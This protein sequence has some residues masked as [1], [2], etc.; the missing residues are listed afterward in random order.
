MKFLCR[1]GM[2]G[3]MFLAL[4]VAAQ[5]DG[6]AF[7]GQWRQLTST[8]GDCGKC[9]IGFV[10]HGDLL[11][12]TSNTGW[13][14]VVKIEGFADVELAVGKGRWMPTVS[15]IYGGKPFSIQFVRRG[16]RLQMHMVASQANGEPLPIRATFE[17]GP[18]NTDPRRQVVPI[19]MQR[20]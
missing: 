6:H 2:A 11:T 20:I 5:A 10:R 14:A 15:G 17:K 13:Q 9:Y 1:V 3:L 18:P 8:A 7:A 16:E 19:Q 12:V 4:A